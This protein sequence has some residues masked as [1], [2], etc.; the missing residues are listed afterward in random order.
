MEFSQSKQRTKQDG[1]LG[2]NIRLNGHRHIMDKNISFKTLET[3]LSSYKSL[4]ELLDIDHGKIHSLIIFWGDC[5]FK[6][7][8]PP[9][10]IKEDCLMASSRNYILSKRE[11]LLSQDELDRICLLLTEAKK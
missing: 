8:M 11:V 4:S 9:N 6:T 5:E 1:F 2:T 7:R 10:V 3:K